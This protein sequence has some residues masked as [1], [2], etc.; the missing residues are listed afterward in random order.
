MKMDV[1]HTYKSSR[2]KAKFV[3]S[4]GSESAEDKFADAFHALQPGCIL[5]I[6]AA[7]EMLGRAHQNMLCR[8][9]LAYIVEREELGVLVEQPR[10]FVQNITEL[11]EF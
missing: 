6:V 3:L 7:F 5:D 2:V 4:I 8:T 10:P 1:M 9:S 11:A